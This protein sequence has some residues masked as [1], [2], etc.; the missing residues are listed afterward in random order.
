MSVNTRPK[1]AFIAYCA[2]AERLSTPGIGLIQA[3]IPFLAE[4]CHEFAGELF[5]AQAFSD[6][7]AERFGIRIP[8]LA[9]LGLAE[10]LA[11]EGLLKIVSEGRGAVVYRYAKSP[12]LSEA[13]QANPVTE[14]EVEAVL[15][16][17]VDYTKSD[18]RLIHKDEQFLESA[19]LNRLLNLDSMRILSR[20]EASIAAKKTAGTLVLNKPS[21]FI[22][23]QDAEEL[24][25]D[26]LVSQ[27][28]IDLRDSDAVAFERVSN[29][30]FANMAAEAI[31]CF[32]ESTSDGR[33][34]ETLTVY[35]DSPLL[36]D[37]LGVNTEYAEYGHEL[38]EAIKASGATPAVF[39][40]CVAEAESAIHAQLNYL[41]SG[42][43]QLSAN[44]GI[45]TKPDLLSA[46][47]GNVAERVNARLG[48]AVHKDPVVQLHR[49][50]PD[51]VGD[52]EASMVTRMQA[53]RNEEAKEYDRK[54]VWAMLA[55]RDALEPCMRI[56]DSKW[57]LLTRNTPLVSI[58][59]NAW[60]AWLKGSTK[61]SHSHIERWAPIAMS[62][63]QFSGY[64][65]TRAGSGNGEISKA[66]LLAHCSAAIRPRT[67]VKARAYNLILELN[68]NAAADD[69][70]ALLE[71]REGAKALMRATHGDPE[72]VTAKRLPFII[73][74][75]KLAA[76]EYAAAKVR[77][78][79]NQNLEAERRTHELE[80]KRLRDSATLQKAKSEEINRKIELTLIQKQ[81][82]QE[83]LESQNRLLNEELEQQKLKESIRK[84]L[85]LNDGFK[86]G[87]RVY[88]ALRWLLALGFASAFG[89]VT[90]ISTSQPLT[91][92]FLAILLGFIS[93]WFV[94][95]LLDKPL[96]YLAKK[97]LTIVVYSKD[98]T[99]IIPSTEPNFK[100]RK[101]ISV[102]DF[103]TQAI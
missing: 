36:L 58:A 66:R 91:A 92:T 46:L 22:N 57:V 20:R 59:N 17:F 96:I 62:D 65:W 53:W 79:A 24:H 97:R 21:D 45:G 78:E 93:F 30:A 7:V 37:M 60:S 39:D 42:V 23:E 82:D 94:P 56:C 51:T 83:S 33:S 34:L 9:A 87:V 71:D 69:I 63:K 76:G 77:E 16:S 95:E 19:F 50:S 101:W 13:L 81:L 88:C 55:I 12:D 28:L 85:I 44:W 10:Q 41:R 14:S 54:S 52:I 72:D 74:Q 86:A 48:I 8:R 27:F 1:R 31:A 102:T 73:E 29:V 3:L 100:N 61:H 68:G 25:L 2:L 90:Y 40:H 84:N 11:Q 64:L 32:Q 70:A 103:K 89:Y 5:E 99:I 26:F 80:L 75:V 47:A 15:K 18:A 98:S 38:L 4:A 6:A 67:D 35:L 43:N 49:R